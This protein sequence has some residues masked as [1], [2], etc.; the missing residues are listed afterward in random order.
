MKG[1]ILYI[2]SVPDNVYFH[3]VVD[4][5]LILHVALKKTDDDFVLGSSNIL[6]KLSHHFSMI[7]SGSLRN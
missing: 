6:S 4:I 7:S 5:D 2:S 3:P 1:D